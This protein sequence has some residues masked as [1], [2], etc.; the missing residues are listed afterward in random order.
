MNGLSERKQKILFDIL[1]GIMLL[2]VMILNI[3]MKS[4]LVLSV[5]FVITILYVLSKVGSFLKSGEVEKF[6]VLPALAIGMI[7]S[8]VFQPFTV[9]DELT[10]FMTGYEFANKIQ[11]ISCQNVENDALGV[12]GI[13][14]INMN[15]REVDEVLFDYPT[16]FSESQLS[17]NVDG[18]GLFV[19][20]ST[21]VQKNNVVI[22]KYFPVPE[23][24]YSAIVI[25]IGRFINLSPFALVW[26][27]RIM[28]LVAYILLCYCA[29]KIIPVGKLMMYLICIMPLSLQQA[30][31]CSYDS[32]L[33]AT[34][35]LYISYMLR[36]YFREKKIS[37]KEIL[38]LLTYSFLLAP[39]KGVFVVLAFLVFLIPQS[40]FENR[41][42]YWF[43]I[44]G[45][46]GLSIA[47]WLMY[48]L[49]SVST[50]DLFSSNNGTRVV[51]WTG[52]EGVY[53]STILQNPFHY[54][55]IIVNTILRTCFY[56]TQSMTQLRVQ[57]GAFVEIA[58]L[59]LFMAASTICDTD[60]YELG[61]GAKWWF[62]LVFLAGY[63]LYSVLTLLSFGKPDAT[64]VELK[65]QYI[66][67]F[68]PIIGLVIRNK[69]VTR[70][71][72]SGK[73]IILTAIILHCIIFFR[74]YMAAGLL[75]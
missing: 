30:S 8:M 36:L 72:E 12:K 13:S 31:S 42:Q 27:V 9:G 6:F 74:I 23:Y 59:I 39:V 43:T 54:I 69:M 7:Y 58:F 47:S 19:K 3:S 24:L 25:I 5:C 73:Y 35:F 21:Y 63:V 67:P 61:K 28:N 26:F 62:F 4:F 66:A 34:V 64:M 48:N 17:K 32:L 37:N 49:S 71:W 40:R 14:Y 55:M 46:V 41:K 2:I 1:I 68:L 20:N 16:A 75:I 10:H 57:V 45:V 52:Q 44:V 60:R 15:I 33:F 50:S 56:L 70:K 53:V 29:I 51:E 22:A 18:Q 38:F 65:G 11:G